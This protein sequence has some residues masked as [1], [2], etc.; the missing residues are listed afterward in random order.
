MIDGIPRRSRIDLYTP[1]EKAI[2]DAL[3]VVES[4]GAHPLL[5]DAVVL[6]GEAQDKV[7]DFV[8][9]QPEH[10][11]DK[12]CW[13]APELISGDSEDGTAVYIHKQTS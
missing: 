10:T 2:N 3:E 6:L 4:T 11:T 1:A 5:T 12:N 7:A 9:L 8:E 13:C